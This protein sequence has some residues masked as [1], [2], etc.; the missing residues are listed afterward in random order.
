MRT[1]VALTEKWD[2]ML[3]LL[4]LA[5]V[6]KGRALPMGNEMRESNSRI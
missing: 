1:S 3:T 4:A 6:R 2:S 5:P